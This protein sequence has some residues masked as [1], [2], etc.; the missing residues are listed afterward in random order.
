MF[1]FCDHT[2]ENNEKFN[3][4]TQKSEKPHSQ[5]GNSGAIYFYASR[6]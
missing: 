3:V 6:G 2:L 4:W 5:I 1:L